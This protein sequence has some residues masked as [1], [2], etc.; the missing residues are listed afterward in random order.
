M[1]NKHLF[2]NHTNEINETNKRKKNVYMQDIH[3]CSV[4]CSVYKII[5]KK[6]VC[7]TS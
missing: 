2:S 1:Y 4:W 6:N 7:Q 5:T 3:R